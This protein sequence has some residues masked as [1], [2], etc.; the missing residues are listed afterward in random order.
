M[1]IVITGGFGFIGS[2]ATRRFLDDGHK[3]TLLDN[4]T[5]HVTNTIP[6]ANILL[7]DLLDSNTL[8]VLEISPCDCFLHMGGISSGPASINDPVGTVSKGYAM[9]YNAL[10]LA[11]RLKTR[12]FLF[13][14]SMTVYGEINPEDCPI[15][16]NAPCQPISHYGIG[17]F[18]NERLVEIFCRRKDIGFNNLRL[19]NVYGP[20]QD[21]ARR[22]QGLVS[23]FLA[24]LME[25][26]K[27]VSRGDLK[28]F[29]D[30]VYIDDVVNALC[31]C[32]DESLIS[33]P[34]NIGC[35]QSITI[36][37]LI[38]ELAEALGI[39]SDLEV[40]VAEGIPGDIYGI[41]ADIS[42]FR[43]ATGYTPRYFPSE[44]IQK[45]T[46]WAINSKPTSQISPP[47]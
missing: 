23:I 39:R 18:A 12:R 40:E 21:L 24:L 3:V 22:D 46:D 7:A 13:T 4:M 37:E 5:S 32:I 42:A 20:G 33:G 27:V 2:K 11:E 31:L 44:G 35:G 25:N 43:E 34:F 14:S 30:I 6:G 47:S 41:C 15:S 10:S 9:T 17:K 1:H 8:N 36:G 28:R 29:R 19:F 45:F 38:L 16:E 26:P